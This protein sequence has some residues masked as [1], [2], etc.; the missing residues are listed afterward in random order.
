MGE[1]ER[2]EWQMLIRAVHVRQF[3]LVLVD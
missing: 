2:Q 3:T 1:E